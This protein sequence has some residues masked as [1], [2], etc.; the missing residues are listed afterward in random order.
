MSAPE[1]SHQR[2][3]RINT[4]LEAALALPAE[5]RNAW[6]AGL[7]PEDQPLRATL[8][9]LLARADVETDDFLRRP[10]TL[11]G[12]DDA[13]TS[14]AHDA[15]GDRV[16]PYRLVQVLGRGGM[17]TV[18]LAERESDVASGGLQRTVALK[19]P[20]QGLGLGKGL[21]RRMA[22]E[23]D[24]LA[25]LEHPHIAR[26]YEAGLTDQGRP[27]LAMQRVDGLPLDAYC[28]RHPLGVPARLRLFMQIAGAVAY[29]HARLV[30][31]RDLKP[32]NILVTAQGEVHLL[33][34]GIAALLQDDDAQAAHGLTRT[35]ARANTPDY[36]SPEQVAGH[37]VTVATDVY[38]LGVVLYE[39][40]SGQRPYT[41]S[42]DSLA[43]LEE[44]IL[45]ADVPPPSTRVGSDRRLVRQLQG[46]LD[47]IAAKA[48]R[49][50]PEQRYASVEAMAADVQ[51]HLDGEPVLARPPSRRYR[52]AK[53]LRRHWRAA[54]AVSSV[55]LA[56]GVGLAVATVQWNEAAVQRAAAQRQL[57]HAQASLDF[58][59]S[60]LTEG[61]TN[62][63]PL[64][65]DELLRRSHRF[66]DRETTPL[67]RA[68][69]ADVLAG[70]YLSYGNYRE[71][72][73]VLARGIAGLPPDAAPELLRVMRCRQAHAWSQLQR[74]PEAVAQLDAVIAAAGND[75]SAA[76]YCLRQRAQVARNDS[77]ADR[78]L[79]FASESLRRLDLAG[80]E[81]PMERAMVRAELA[82]AHGLRGQAGLADVEYAAAV[83]E[84][85]AKGRG[86]SVTAVPLLNNW[87][88]ALHNSGRPL[89]ALARFE[90]AAAI[91]R[92]RSPGAQVPSYLLGNI[93]NTQ[94][95]LGRC[96]AAREG[97][98]AM[99][100][101]VLRSGGNAGNLAYARANEAW[102]LLQL[103]Q[104]AAA[105]A[106]LDEAQALHAQ[107]PQALPA[108]APPR[109]AL[110]MTQ[111]QM[112][113]AQARWGDAQAVLD[114]L[115]AASRAAGLR[116][117]LA[118]QALLLRSEAV[119]HLQ[120]AAAAVAEAEAAL[121]L[122]QQLQQGLTHTSLVGQAWLAVAQHRQRAGDT[123][124][125][126]DAYAR[127]LEHLA[128]T[129]GADQPHTLRA[130]Q[131]LRETG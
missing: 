76:S 79:G 84:H 27:W 5:Q 114:A 32:A 118:V 14:D 59:Q 44:A 105:Q 103:G 102:C 58:A 57:A 72:E 53:L 119:L 100:A 35:T 124:R 51:R 7:P 115:L 40:L 101:A 121:G 111:A 122:A 48:L 36:A 41:L 78:A 39:M 29:A 52:L 9:G 66:I 6:L 64:T 109:T 95:A 86:E 80:R 98:A 70:M 42:R 71:A 45:S 90:Q 93:A 18:W 63:E 21:A 108:T 11:G 127:A 30:V 55:V 82:Y 20:V 23:R 130:Q 19:L 17:A 73:P 50:R 91:S 1:A 38:S 117:N 88:I 67:A 94:R 113:L 75:H 96:D 43:A 10:L 99:R 85:L 61:I 12:D 26:L 60:V 116:T 37:A 83:N 87:G 97:F 65:L 62:Q 129:M 128:P 31:H 34:F 131:G 106:A 89:L 92:R 112:H 8:R 77:Q 110:A 68:L 47:T 46:D 28:E 74:V 24:L 104:T 4:L 125:A 107:L 54:A 81:S 33:D 15:P 2:L 3:R 25:G 123:A 69:N 56:L 16:G 22:R 126:H 49:K 120:G 13:A